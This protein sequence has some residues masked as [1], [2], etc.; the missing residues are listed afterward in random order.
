MV[1]WQIIGAVVF[2][3]VFSL[4]GGIILL[5]KGKNFQE[6]RHLSIIT[7]FAVG[8]LITTVFSDLLP[9]ALSEGA[10]VN[11]GLVAALS[12][13][14]AFFILEKLLLWYHHQHKHHDEIKPAVWLI[15]LGDSLH[16]FL[17]G[18]AIATAF[19]LDPNLGLTVAIA[20]FVHEIP[21]EIVDFTILLNHGLSKSKTLFFNFLSALVSLVG[22]VITYYLSSNWQ[23]Y[24]PIVAAFASG[25]LLYIALSD[26]L[27]EM[28]QKEYS[29]VEIIKQTLSL[30]A[31]V[32]LIFLI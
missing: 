7:S 32:L 25:N 20:V 14:I 31:G 24:V 28:Q 1:F 4:A 26:L 8:V 11:E 17:D 22:A 10:S 9:E 3:S 6:G 19:V 15:T 29:Q 18:V 21:H 12:G 16:N 30:L 13:I 2:A 27:P 23:A 5:W